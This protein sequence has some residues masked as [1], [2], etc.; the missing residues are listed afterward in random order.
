[1]SWQSC[2]DRA[3]IIKRNVNKEFHDNVFQNLAQNIKIVIDTGLADSLQIY[4]RELD[5]NKRFTNKE[6]YNSN[7]KQNYEPNI[8]KKVISKEEQKKL[9]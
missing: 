2:L 3:K 5:E 4:L 6:V 1:M 9:R 8:V 7:S